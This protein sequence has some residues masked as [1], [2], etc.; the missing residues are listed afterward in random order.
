M[1]RPSSIIY[2]PSS[3]CTLPA[4]RYTLGKF[5]TK[6]F[7]RNF[8]QILQNEPNFPL[9]SPKNEDLNEKRTQT[10]PNK[11]DFSLFALTYSS[12]SVGAIPNFILGAKMMQNIYLQRIK[13]K[14]VDCLK[15]KRIL[16]CPEF[17]PKV[18]SRRIKS[19][20]K[21]SGIKKI[22]KRLFPFIYPGFFKSKQSYT[23]GAISIPRSFLVFIFRLCNKVPSINH[24]R[25][26]KVRE[27]K[28]T[29]KQT[30]DNLT[31]R[32]VKQRFCCF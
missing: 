30:N 7:V 4:V 15:L 19:N 11:L 2:H 29:I 9:F 3:T 16:S 17:M 31:K 28:L 25:K 10:N 26:P 22:Y 21:L 1:N 27:K 5:S 8:Q 12:D 20:F 23:M 32:R 24:G 6:D 14:N 18:R 13:K